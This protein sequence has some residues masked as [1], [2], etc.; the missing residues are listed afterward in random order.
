MP[1]LGAQILSFPYTHFFRKVL[2][3]FDLGS[4][5]SVWWS[6]LRPGGR[7]SVIGQPAIFL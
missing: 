5:R 1:L 3:Q 6:V 2:L 7:I 4:D